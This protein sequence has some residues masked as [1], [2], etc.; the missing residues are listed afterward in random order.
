MSLSAKAREAIRHAMA[1]KDAL[2]DEVADAIDSN[3][4]GPAAVVAALTEN[5]GAI[6]G[7]NDGNLPDLTATYVARTGSNSGT[8]DGALQA[9]GTLTTAGGNTY[10]DA[11]VN[12]ILAK[13]E[14][15]IAEAFAVIAQLAAD[16]VAL[17]AAAREN[18]AEINAILTALKAVDM[19]A[20]S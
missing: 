15:N 1:G 8:A 16:N 9:E 13:V 5:S 12:T 20:S 7:T 11:A 2:G 14:N 18:A 3:G 17:R 19:M 10:T 6:G 4:S